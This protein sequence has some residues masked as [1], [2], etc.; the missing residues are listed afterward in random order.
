MTSNTR[1]PVLMY[2]RVGDAHIEWKRKYISTQ[3]FAACTGIR[4]ATGR[5][6]ALRV[7]EQ[8]LVHLRAPNRSERDAESNV[9]IVRLKKTMT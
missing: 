6:L 1:L 3:D 5:E 2:H 8:G 4:N 9:N 7:R